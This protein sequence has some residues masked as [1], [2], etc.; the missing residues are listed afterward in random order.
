MNA[1]HDRGLS[2][3]EL[4]LRHQRGDW[5]DL[6]AGDIEANR[7]ALLDGSRLL[8]AYDLGEGWRVWVITEAD[9]R[10]TCLLLPD[11]Y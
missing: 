11:E 8:S 6:D 9:R 5:G 10:S 1:L 3:M 7:L 4:F 2:A